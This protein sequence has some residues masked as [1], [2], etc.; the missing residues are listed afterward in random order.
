MAKT[1]TPLRTPQTPIASETLPAGKQ[2]PGLMPANPPQ[3]AGEPEN[4]NV[5]PAGPGKPID[6]SPAVNTYTP[7]G[8]Q[9]AEFASG[10]Q[11]WPALV[12]ETT[13]DVEL[14]PGTPEPNPQEADEPPP[15]PDSKPE[16]NPEFADQHE[17]QASA[18]ER[19]IQSRRST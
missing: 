12:S 19:L 14:P 18:A 8:T 11:D 16:S 17:P 10:A 3:A 7:R 4:T 1:K 2:T 9:A 13:T 5:S 6:G 15:P